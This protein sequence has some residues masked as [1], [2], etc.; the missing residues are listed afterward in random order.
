MKISRAKEVGQLE[1]EQV[2]GMV[3]QPRSLTC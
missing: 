3:K 1:T 2:E